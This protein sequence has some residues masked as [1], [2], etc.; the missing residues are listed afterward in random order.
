MKALRGSNTFIVQVIRQ[1][2]LKAGGRDSCGKCMWIFLWFTL[3]RLAW[4]CL[5]W[6]DLGVGGGLRKL[7][8]VVGRLMEC[9]GAIV[10][11]SSC[12]TSRARYVKTVM[13]LHDQVRETFRMWGYPQLQSFCRIIKIHWRR[14]CCIFAAVC[15]DLKLMFG[16]PQQVVVGDRQ[17]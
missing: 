1:Q 4:S 16:T 12:L 8:I 7:L 10:L 5:Y 17:W 9:R 15:F 6:E 14:S 13:V 11:G 3:T 2:G